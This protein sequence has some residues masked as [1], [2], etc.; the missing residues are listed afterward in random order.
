M[1]CNSYVL[2]VHVSEDGDNVTL[3]FTVSPPITRRR[4]NGYG[5]TVL[6]GDAGT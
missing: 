4:T 1:C 6:G 5:Y 2:D 3:M